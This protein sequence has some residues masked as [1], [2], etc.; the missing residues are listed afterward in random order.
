MPTDKPVTVAVVTGGHSYDV[1]NFHR[2]LGGLD[3]VD[4]YV[5]HMDD[6]ASSPDE[7]RD[8]YD[9][10]LFYTMLMETPP[11][12]GLPWYCGD[13]RGAVE[14]LGETRQG[15]LL[16]HHAIL[17]WSEWP[18]WDRIVGI[19]KREFDYFLDQTVTIEVADD[20][21]PITA[22]LSGWTMGDETYRV[23]E[24]ADDSRILLTLDHPESMKSICWVRRHRQSPVLCLQSGHDN[25]TWR[26]ESFRTVLRRGILWCAG[27]L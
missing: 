13:P 21:H 24:P 16:L 3:G 8:A 1:M 12:E 5:Q 14:H 6:W 20:A 11:A 15:I 19:E 17:A 2:L 4:A 18:V 22:G 26:E 7:V 25:V 10:V 9:V 27:R 23:A